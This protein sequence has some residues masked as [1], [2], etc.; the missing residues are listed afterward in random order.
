MRNSSWLIP[1]CGLAAL[2]CTTA[3]G[4]VYVDSST[5]GSETG[6]S[7]RDAR[8]SIG[9][10]LDGA[11]P[12][13][14]IWI[15]AGV[16]R[17][18]CELGVKVPGLR[19]YGGFKGFE[20]DLS[21]RTIGRSP[22]VVDGNHAHR[23]FEIASTNVL[24]DGLTIAHG[25]ATAGG[26]V[27]NHGADLTIQSC[28]ITNCCVD[29]AANGEGGGIRSDQPMRVLDSAFVACSNIFGFNQNGIG[30][31][32]VFNSDGTLL[33][34]NTVFRGNVSGEQNTG[35]AWHGCGGAIFLFKGTLDAWN[36]TFDGN[37]AYGRNGRHGGAIYGG[38]LRINQCTFYDNRASGLGGAIFTEGDVAITNSI[39]WANTALKGGPNDLRARSARIT[40]SCLS[41]VG[42]DNILATEKLV[43]SGIVM[44]DPL[45]VDP[46]GHDFHL[47]RGRINLGADEAADSGWLAPSGETPVV[48]SREPGRV[49]CTAATPGLVLLAGQWADGVLYWGTRDG[50]TEAD[51][52]EHATPVAETLQDGRASQAELA[53]LTPDTTYYYRG[54]A[55]NASGDAWAPSTGSFRTGAL[56]RGSPD[57]RVIHVDAGNTSRLQDGSCWTYAYRDLAT[58]WS[59]LAGETNTLWIAAGAY[60]CGKTLRDAPPNLN[61]YGGFSGAET[62]PEQREVV[63]H[64]SIL[65]GDAGDDPQHS[66]RLLELSGTHARVDALTFV[67][68]AAVQND[69]GGGAIKSRVGDLEICNCTFATNTAAGRQG[70]GGALFL[71]GDARVSNCVF[72]GNASGMPAGGEGDGGAVYFQKDAGKLDIRNSVFHGNT[73]TSRDLDAPRK[74]GAVYAD[75]GPSG[76]V[77]VAFC[78]F[79]ANAAGS[80]G[81]AIAMVAGDLGISHS[82]LWADEHARQVA[83]YGREIWVGGKAA[84]R[85]SH[86]NVDTHGIDGAG[87]REFG[88]D[89]VNTD[90]FFADTR[91]P[92]DLHLQSQ[93]GRWTP[94]GFVNDRFTSPCL[95]LGAYGNTPQASRG[96]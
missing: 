51:A 69:D 63:T 35:T 56:R 21:Q 16:Y 29:G 55:T 90:P 19:I 5:S 50:R 39:F 57:P 84:L 7:W 93:F 60:R 91:A 1:F 11:A 2:A 73:C 24:L 88:P 42:G 78:T 18:G 23:C 33:V 92:V 96:R 27:H 9:A 25:Y 89:L 14:E 86:S 28:V 95:E 38:T 8:R 4:R 48:E 53:P 26:G 34:S 36:C 6:D 15:A 64:A 59:R 94:D 72:C 54:Y 81:G 85:L 58:A 17:E 30:C 37:R 68:G 49:E 44:A 3:A 20:T 32:I 76:R 31:G 66:W 45:F 40:H 82:I 75:P 46:A 43:L 13:E 77:E 47:R 61:L 87:V 70:K 41:G 74:G 71:L 22:T 12:G 79:Y 52:W 83:G 65:L 62:S 80:D 67:G 10:A